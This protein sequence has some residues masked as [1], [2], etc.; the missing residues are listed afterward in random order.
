MTALSVPLLALVLAAAATTARAAASGSPL[1][2]PPYPALTI[3]NTQLRTLPR[4]ANGRD[5]LLY[6]S[7]PAAYDKDPQ[8]RYPVMYVTDGYWDFPLLCA[9]NGN[10]LYDQVI[11]DIIIVGIGYQG[12]NPNYDVLRR[13][14]LTPVADATKDTDETTAGHAAEFLSVVEKEI[15]PFIEREYRADPAYRALGGSSIGGLFTLYALFTRPDFFQA[16]VAI[17]P[18]VDWGH[19][20]IFRYEDEFAKSGRPLHARLFLTGAS[21]E[22]P[23]LISSILSFNAQIRARHY[24]GFTYAWRLV[25]GERHS[26]TKA[27]GYNRGVRFAF[28]PLVPK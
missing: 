12:E 26:G 6:V 11:P 4:A 16:Y 18:G 10:L 27:E 22:W 13:Y 25:D 24:D 5:Y 7:L 17:S 8:R 2:P 15:V 3:A 28:A 20:W 14:D 9:F 1:T 19:Q 21:D 23:F